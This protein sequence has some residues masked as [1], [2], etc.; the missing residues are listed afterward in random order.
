M[1]EISG[2]FDELLANGDTTAVLGLASA[3]SSTLN[4]V[5]S[6]GANG[7]GSS[8]TDPGEQEKEQEVNMT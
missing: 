6:G 4:G 7:T 3:L 5:G 8:V 1:S 2:R